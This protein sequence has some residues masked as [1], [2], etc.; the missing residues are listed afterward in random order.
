[1]FSVSDLN[2]EQFQGA[3]ILWFNYQ[4]FSFYCYFVYFS[5]VLFFNLLELA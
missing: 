1:M 2:V 3:I 4:Y 5:M